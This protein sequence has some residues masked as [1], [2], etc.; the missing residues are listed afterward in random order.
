MFDFLEVGV[1]VKMFFGG[2]NFQAE[3]TAASPA[4]TQI[5]FAVDPQAHPTFH[6]Q[7]TADPVGDYAFDTPPPIGFDIQ[8]TGIAFVAVDAALRAHVSNHIVNR[9]AI[10][11]QPIGQECHARHFILDAH[12]VT[13]APQPWHG[14]ATAGA[15]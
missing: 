2:P 15:D 1:S 14:G 4:H 6:G 12:P 11:A 3:T 9:A 13:G 8:W 5:F 7:F 10:S